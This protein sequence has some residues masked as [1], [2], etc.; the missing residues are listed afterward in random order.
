MEIRNIT[1]ALARC[2][3]PKLVVTGI[4]LLDSHPFLQESVWWEKTLKENGSGVQLTSEKDIEKYSFTNPD[5]YEEWLKEFDRK[6]DSAKKLVNIYMM[7]RDPYKLTFMK[8]NGDFMSKKQF[9]EYLAD[10]WVTEDNPN[11]DI[12][13]PP[14]E[15]IEMFKKAEKKWL[16]TEEDYAYY[17]NLPDEIEVFRGVSVGRIKHGL[18]WTDDKEKAEWFRKRFQRKGSKSNG[19][20]NCCMLRAVV[21]KSDVLAYFNTRNEKELVVNV[22]NIIDKI[23]EI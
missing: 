18:S 20:E 10:A 23:E 13:V 12:N 1:K 9:A 6:V 19:D 7:Y 2:V 21:K 15:S 16:M 17:H 5:I 14:S 4:P 22:F 8:F 11:M 3:V